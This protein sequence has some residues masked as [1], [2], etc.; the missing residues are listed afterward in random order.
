MQVPLST[1]LEL[2]TY[3]KLQNL[4]RQTGQAMTKIIDIALTEYMDRLS[5]QPEE[6]SIFT[7]EDVKYV[8]QDLKPKVVRGKDGKFQKKERN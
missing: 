8:N 3:T 6:I 4:S 5:R 2:E 1:K 7:D